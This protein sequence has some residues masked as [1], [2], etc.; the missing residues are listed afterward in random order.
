MIG[1]A[2]YVQGNL[3]LDDVLFQ[4]N[5]EGGNPKAL[6]ID[7]GATLEVIGNMDMN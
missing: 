7:P 4:N 1:G 3:V 5:F 2:L 6:T